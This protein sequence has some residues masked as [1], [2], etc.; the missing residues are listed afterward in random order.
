MYM[1]SSGY[2]LTF[3]AADALKVFDDPS[4]R[5]AAALDNGRGLAAFDGEPFGFSDIG[6]VWMTQPEPD[7]PDTWPDWYRKAAPKRARAT[8]RECFSFIPTSYERYLHEQEWVTGCVRLRGVP[9]LLLVESDGPIA[10]GVWSAK[11]DSYRDKR[12]RIAREL[13]S[14]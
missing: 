12:I 14:A 6:T 7:Y 13:I 1:D 10:A 2:V 11:V 5:Y 9:E 3:D 8:G 4:V